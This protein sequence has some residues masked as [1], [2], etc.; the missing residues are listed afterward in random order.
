MAMP[1]AAMM[2]PD[3]PTTPTNARKKR[4][5]EVASAGPERLLMSAG[6]HAGPA[7]RAA[8]PGLSGPE[9]VALGR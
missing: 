3:A 9:T 6:R 5:A 1:P 4:I 2:E 8:R 7:Q